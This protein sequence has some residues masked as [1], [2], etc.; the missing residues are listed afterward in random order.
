MILL[1]APAMSMVMILSISAFLLMTLLLVAVL[2]YAK[3]KLLPEGVVKLNINGK[4]EY[5]LTVSPGSSLLST[6]GDNKILLPSACGGGGTCGMCECVVTSGGGDVLPTEKP[7]FSRKQ[8]QSNHRLA[9]QVK[10][11]QDINIE[12]PQEIL[13]IKKWECEV[14][15]NHN[16]SPNVSQAFQP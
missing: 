12:I 4:P 7:F 15:S 16:F 9:C 1:E 3:A 11:K 10:V 5:D 8:L 2:L 6:L 13:G 14:V